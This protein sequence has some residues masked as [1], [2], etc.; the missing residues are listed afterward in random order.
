MYID[1][2]KLSQTFLIVFFFQKRERWFLPFAL[3]MSRVW[4]VAFFYLF[5]LVTY[6]YKL[7]GKSRPHVQGPQW[8]SDTE[9]QPLADGEVIDTNQPIKVHPNLD[10]AQPWLNETNRASAAIVILVSSEEY[11]SAQKTVVQLE[12]NFNARFQYPY[13]F[14]NDHPYEELFRQNMYRL[15]GHR[16]HYGRY[17]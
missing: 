10:T 9:P 12:K 17:D 11:T 13:V 2:G 3:T 1:L 16:A 6:I 15:V 5:L 8:G 7:D 4:A 14:I